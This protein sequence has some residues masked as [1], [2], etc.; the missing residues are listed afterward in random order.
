MSILEEPISPNSTTEQRS[1][2]ARRWYQNDELVSVARAH[3]EDVET[4]YANH[5]A[6]LINDTQINLPKII[7]IG[8]GEGKLASALPDFEWYIGVD[9]DPCGLH[10]QD[11]L[12]T[13][14]SK[15][16]FI[17]GRVEA[18]PPGLPPSDIVVSSLSFALWPDPI[19][20]LRSLVEQVKE[21]G[22]LLVLDLLR[23]SP[24]LPS[25]GKDLQQQFLIDQ[26]N[27]SL[28]LDEVERVRDLVLPNAEIRI[29]LDESEALRQVKL[30]K[31]S[32][33]HV[34]LLDY[35]RREV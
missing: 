28:T 34:F 4:S 3:D 30:P 35:Q 7:D 25:Q 6:G 16:S 1:E 11:G 13:G 9:P 22:R 24:P 27:A 23:N 32:F 20:N 5:M 8:C 14:A 18:L 33:G 10:S 26:Y 29:F 31:S 12:V 2:L 21:G 17:R 19:E 15:S